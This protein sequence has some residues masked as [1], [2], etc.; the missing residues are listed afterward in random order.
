MPVRLVALD[1]GPDITLDRTMVVVG[2]HP[3]C[4]TRLDSLRVSRHHCCM[5]QENGEVDGQGPGQHQRHPDQRSAGGD[6]PAAARAMSCRSLIFVIV[7]RTARL[8]SRRSPSRRAWRSLG[9]GAEDR[10]GGPI[11]DRLRLPRGPAAGRPARRRTARRTPWRPRCGSSSRRRRR[12]VPNPGHRADGRATADSDDGSTGRSA[13]EPTLRSNASECHSELVPLNQGTAPIIA[14]HR[15]VVLI[16]RHLDCDVRID[17]PKIS[18]RHCCVAM[19]YDRVLVRDLGSRNGVRVNGRVVEE[20]RLQPGD[21]LAI[22]PILY[23]FEGRGRGRV[24]PRRPGAGG[25]PVA[26]GS[27]SAPRRDAPRARAT[28]A[29]CSMTRTSTWSRSTTSSRSA[30]RPESASRVLPMPANEPSRFVVPPSGRRSLGTEWQDVA[31]HAGSR[32]SVPC[33]SSPS[34]W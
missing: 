11:G 2:R 34:V 22:G 30:R 32:L 25:K 14:L 28:P 5:T 26:A 19:A 20:V 16:G 24:A 7:S 15:P 8:T 12:Q 27:A 29:G 9:P 21:E 13:P 6:R 4:D 3:A 10:A 17:H 31:S 1:E 33:P 23:R 18:R